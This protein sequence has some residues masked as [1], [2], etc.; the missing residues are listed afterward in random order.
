MRGCCARVEEFP[1]CL[2]R[3]ISLEFKEMARADDGSLP[4]LGAPSSIFD[5]TGVRS[6]AVKRAQAGSGR[7]KAPLEKGMSG[8]KFMSVS[9][10]M[11]KSTG[12]GITKKIAA[13]AVVLL[14]GA[15]LLPA[16]EVGGEA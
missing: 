3:G 13:A 12:L 7:G 2:K 9:L 8:G 15:R 10:D 6:F 16:Q 5:R 4:E 14:L 1:S 11:A